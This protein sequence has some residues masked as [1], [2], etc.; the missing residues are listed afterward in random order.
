M[1][2][3]INPLQHIGA[4][5]RRRGIRFRRHV[6]CAGLEAVEAESLRVA[7][8]QA[9]LC[10]SLRRKTLCGSRPEGGGSGKQSAAVHHVSVRSG[11]P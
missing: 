3:I 9:S 11:G 10:E 8:L 5:A 4:R 1:G 7:K 6:A 2:V